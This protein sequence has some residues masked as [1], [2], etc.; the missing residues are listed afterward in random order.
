MSLWLPRHPKRELRSARRPARGGCRSS[1]SFRY[2]QEWKSI[3]ARA[4]ST[5]RPASSARVRALAGKTRAAKTVV[6]NDAVAVAAEVRL[7]MEIAR[8]HVGEP[9]KY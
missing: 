7:P 9:R 4:A 3:R 6:A 8:A 2:R 5:V 1:C